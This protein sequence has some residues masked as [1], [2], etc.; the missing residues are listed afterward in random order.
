MAKHKNES[1]FLRHGLAPNKCNVFSHLLILI[2]GMI[3]FGVTAVALG[4]DLGWDLAN[5]HYSNPYLFLHHSFNQDFWPASYYHV[6]LTPTAD[7][8]SYFLIN[9]LSPLKATFIAG[10]LQGIDLWLIFLICQILFADKN[11]NIVIALILA[12]IGMFGAIGFTEIGIFKNDHIVSLFVLIFIYY[13]LRFLRSYFYHTKWGIYLICGSISLGI[14]LGLKLSAAPYVLSVFI[15]YFFL[16]IPWKDRWKI[17]TVWSIACG[18]GVCISSG[19][20]MLILWKLHHNPIFPFLNNI[21]HS[22]DFPEDAWYF[23]RYLPHTLLAQLWYPVY[24]SFHG[25]IVDGYFRDLR[26]I[27]LYSLFIIMIIVTLWKKIKRASYQ[28]LDVALYWLLIFILFTYVFGQADFG[29]LRY[30]LIL[31]MLSPV[32]IYLLM[33]QLIAHK[34]IRNISII[35]LF[36]ILIITLIPQEINSRFTSYKANYFSVIPPTFANSS[37]NA[38]VLISYSEFALSLTPRPISFLIGFLPKQW[39]FIGIPFNNGLYD[40]S[41]KKAYKKI[42]E[43]IK[44]QTEKIYL[45]APEMNMSELYL[46]ALHF[47]LVASGHCEVVGNIRARLLHQDVIMCP[48]SRII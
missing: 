25:T 42:Y 33:Q 44:N 15:S 5:Y 40:S 30:I 36:F 13:Q 34:K 32:L 2:L 18:I 37:S 19:Y 1:H 3:F 29:S 26:Y 21:F 31:E 23:Q 17:I 38:T 4:R 9:Y 46:A 7:F 41:D 39:H 47:N 6:Y 16:P 22:P 12:F 11:N 48:V 43:L 35:S 27:F 24:F 14:A 45:L 8:L 10:A 28:K 20:W